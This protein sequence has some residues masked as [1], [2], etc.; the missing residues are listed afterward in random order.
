MGAP[1]M[2]TEM[3]LGVYL[4]WPWGGHQDSLWGAP[5]MVIRVVS[6]MIPRQSSGWSWIVLWVL[7]G[8]SWVIPR[9]VPRVL[10]GWCLGREVPG[11]SPGMEPGAGWKKERRKEGGRDLPGSS[12]EP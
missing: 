7:L 10:L 4:G 5:R 2:V 3:V 12:S 1:G 9:V 8:W 11:V 6:G